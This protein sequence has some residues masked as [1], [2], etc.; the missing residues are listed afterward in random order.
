MT[1]LRFCNSYYYYYCHITPEH[2]LPTSTYWLLVSTSSWN[3][4]TTCNA[5]AEFTILKKLTVLIKLIKKS[6]Q[7]GF[8]LRAPV[9]LTME[10]G[11]CHFLLWCL[12]F[13][14]FLMMGGP[15]WFCEAYLRN[16]L[17]SLLHLQYSS[18]I[19]SINKYLLDSCYMQPAELTAGEGMQRGK[20]HSHCESEIATSGELN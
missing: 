1:C 17:P 10:Q 15:V 5:N 3:F 4:V 11:W 8:A 19:C 2:S 13:C 6:I 7:S 14:P 9:L 18:F 12:H 20:R 16:S